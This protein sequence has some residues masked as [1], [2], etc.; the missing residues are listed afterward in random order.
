MEPK[1]LPTDFEY[2]VG[3]GHQS[4]H[5]QIQ[6]LANFQFRELLL[7]HFTILEIVLFSTN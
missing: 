6:R 2:Y 3:H 4:A 1:E 5:F 7:L